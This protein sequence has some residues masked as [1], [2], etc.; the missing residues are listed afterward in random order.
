[1]IHLYLKIPDLAAFN[2]D[3]KTR[4]QA[5]G[6]SADFDQYTYSIPDADG[7]NCW[8][9]IETDFYTIATDEEKA[10]MLDYDSAIAEGMV[11]GE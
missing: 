1:M 10:V 11:T 2:T 7:I 3:A 9:K 8:A 4:M 6:I 5:G